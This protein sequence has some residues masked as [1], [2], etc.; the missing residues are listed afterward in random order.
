VV[1]L[2]LGETDDWAHAGNYGEYLES[3]HRVDGYMKDLWDQLQS[4]AEYKG[5]T[6]MIFLVD[7]GR[8]SAPEEWKGHGQKI[9]ESKY[10]FIG[11]MGRGVPALGL[12]ENVAPVMQSQVAAT[13]AKYLGL[14]WNAAEKQAGLP[15][16]DA[17]K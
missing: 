12:R 16:K 1:F 13:L 14:D 5:K 4:M 8:G 17:L 7:H 9:P 15:V 2:S 11:F 10:I 3:A 6:T